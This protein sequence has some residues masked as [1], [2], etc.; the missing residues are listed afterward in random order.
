VVLSHLTLVVRILSL[1]GGVGLLL[2]GVLM[3][4][5]DMSLLTSWGLSFF[6]TIYRPLLPYM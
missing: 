3:V 5:G 2:T 1:V 6:D 4:L